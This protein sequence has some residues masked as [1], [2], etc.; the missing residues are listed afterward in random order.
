MKNAIFNWLE[1]YRNTDIDIAE[2]KKSKEFTKS[3][4]RKIEV[5]LDI[6]Q[7]LNA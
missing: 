6:P 1:E 4:N 2:N 7:K 5:H 3:L